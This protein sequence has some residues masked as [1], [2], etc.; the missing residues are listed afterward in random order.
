MESNDLLKNSPEKWEE[1]KMFMG[2]IRTR[3]KASYPSIQMTE[4]I[5]LHNWFKPEVEDQNEYIETIKNYINQFD[6]AAI[7]FYPFFKGQRS[8]NQF[9]KAFDFLHN[10]V[11]KPIAFVETNHLAE[12]L[13]IESFEITIDGDEEEQNE[14]LETLLLTR[15]NRITVLLFGGLTVIMTNYG[16]L[17]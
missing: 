7:S 14:Y 17:F 10:N 11:S 16:K 13:V 2:N 8:K 1:F 12:N 9:Q 4:S 5:T 15:I 3:I 6:F